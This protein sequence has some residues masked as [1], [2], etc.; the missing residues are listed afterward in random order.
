MVGNLPTVWERMQLQQNEKE[1]ARHATD[2]N[3]PGAQANGAS[4]I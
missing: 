4:T 3:P 2:A 1:M